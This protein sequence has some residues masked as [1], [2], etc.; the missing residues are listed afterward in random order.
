MQLNCRKVRDESNILDGLS[1][2]PI[3]MAIVAS[4]VVLQVRGQYTHDGQPARRAYCLV[5]TVEAPVALLLGRSLSQ[6]TV[7]CSL[8]EVPVG[9]EG[10]AEAQALA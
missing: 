4:E 6:Q 8:K 2:A 10:F 9:P 7:S 3:F 5:S 1:Q